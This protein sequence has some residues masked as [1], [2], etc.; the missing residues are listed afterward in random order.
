MS[1]VADTRRDT[2]IVYKMSRAGVLG[3]SIG[4]TS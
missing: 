3:W 2:G 1:L 4:A